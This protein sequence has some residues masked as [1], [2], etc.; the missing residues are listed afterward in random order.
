MLNSLS[1]DYLTNLL[2]ELKEEA[3]ERFSTKGDETAAYEYALKSIKYREAMEER[4]DILRDITVYNDGDGLD[5]ATLKFCLKLMRGEHE[6]FDPK[7]MINPKFFEKE[8]ATDLTEIEN[9]D[10]EISE[11]ERLNNIRDMIA[12]LEERI[13]IYK[14]YMAKFVAEY[15]KEHKLY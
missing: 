2:T 4:I 8:C 5:T 13:K 3:S 15:D 11:L 6:D 12:A 10:P 9:T 14:E 1:P 7:T